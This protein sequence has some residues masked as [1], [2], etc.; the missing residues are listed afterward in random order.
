[1]HVIA[2]LNARENYENLFN[3]L[4]NIRDEIEQITT[5]AVNG[6]EYQVE[7]FLG[8]DWKFLALIVGIE[9]ASANYC[10]IW[11]ICHTN[12]RHVQSKEWSV[13]DKAKGARSIEDIQRLANEKRR[14][15]EKYGCV[16]KPIF[17]SI[18]ID[19]VIPDV[20][21]L[22]LR[23]CD[24][25]INL[26]IMELRRMD[27]IDKTTLRKFD[28]NTATQVAKYEE[29]LNLLV[30]TFIWTKTQK[31]SSG[32]ILWGQKNLNFLIR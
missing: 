23:I 3:S 25:L 10:C 2:L 26:L 14:G 4:E 12:E 20:L 13:R 31:A 21:H 7:F 24:V 32:G 30:F 8:A 27:G 29:Y 11:C 22:F 9:S 1:M 16:R 18:A 5:I 17:P 15:K 28:R 6:V 19:H